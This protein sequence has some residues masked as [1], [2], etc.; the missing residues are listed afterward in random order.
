MKAFNTLLRASVFFAGV[1]LFA[2][3]QKETM[4]PDNQEV[5][6]KKGGGSGGNES[7]GNNL[8]FPV[9]WSEGAELA[10][11]TAPTG[12]TD[13]DVLLQGA[14]WYVWGVDPIDPQ[15]PI[16]SCQPNPAN[17]AVCLDGSTPGDGTSTVYKAYL[18]KDARNFWKAYNE[19]ATE[20]VNVDLIDWGDN[21]E[22]IDWNLTSKVRTEVVLYENLPAPVLQYAMRHASGWGVDE[23]HGLQTE[24]NNTVITGPG[25][26]A[27]V[28]S[29]HARLTIQRLTSLSPNL[30][31]DA[32]NH[33]WIG[34][35][36]A[37]IFSK[38]VHEAA[39]GPGYYNAEVNVKGKIIFGYTWDLK[40]L[41]DGAGVYRI[42]FS[43]DNSG[44]GTVLNTF[45][46]TNTSIITPIEEIEAAAED[47][48]GGTAV[49]DP[50]NNLSY[51]DVVIKA[52]GGRGGR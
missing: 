10:L 18:Q 45:F 22:S 2:S 37:P 16:Y 24:L 31:W 29:R 40:K 46:D 41:N 25:S 23:M 51:I 9:I 34:D 32:T 19:P 26:Q 5:L 30:T 13:T 39:D 49:V 52:R 44:P 14:W 12:L 50:V 33:T 8:S 43:F 17:P 28:F 35:A 36:N 1:I 27:T 4:F 15:A 47:G 7:V 21:L 42:T 11:R 38:A 20:I 6:A 48:G 3:C